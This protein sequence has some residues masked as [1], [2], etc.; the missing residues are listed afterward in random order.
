MASFFPQTAALVHVGAD[1]ESACCLQ[2]TGD[3]AGAPYAGEMMG[4][5][6]REELQFALWGKMNC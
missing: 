3:G 6:E 4:G 1:T 2:L 5:R